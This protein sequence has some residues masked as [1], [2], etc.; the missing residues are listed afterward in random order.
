MKFQFISGLIFGAA[1][2]FSTLSFADT[3]L[4]VRWEQ[5]NPQVVANYQN[6]S[7]AQKE[8]V[9][10]YRGIQVPA[11]KI[12]LNQ[13]DKSY[14]FGPYV[15]TTVDPTVAVLYGSSNKYG[16]DLGCDSVIL[17]MEIPQG[18]FSSS[19]S[20]QNVL[21]VASPYADLRLFVTEVGFFSKS[22][23]AK[24]SSNERYSRGSRVKSIK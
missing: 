16:E 9:Q 20:I 10:V 17:K 5:L 2:M 7:D 13:R 23:A 8:F 6:L 11:A 21:P 15:Y 4:V 14:R 18:F 1:V 19:D 3:S 22:E 12:T 24:L